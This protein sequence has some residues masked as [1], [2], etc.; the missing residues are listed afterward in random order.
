M[1]KFFKSAAFPILIVV[2][3]AFFAQKLIGTSNHQPPYTFGNLIQQLQSGQV[4]SLSLHVSDNTVNLTTVTGQHYTV[5]YPD[6]YA[7]TL[8]T[9]VQKDVQS[10]TE[11]VQDEL[12]KER[13]EVEGDVDEGR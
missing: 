3:L 1:S 8:I 7:T 6:Q 9:D 5:G 2:V 4:K 10:E 11:T 13:V 12:R